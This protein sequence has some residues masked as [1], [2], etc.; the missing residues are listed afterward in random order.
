MKNVLIIAHLLYATPRIPGLA[1]YLRE[2][3]WQPIILTA[4]LPEK[5]N[6][7]FR[8][9]ETSYRDALGLW[10]RLLRINPDEDIRRQVKERF[11]V[12]SKKSLMDFILTCCGAVVNYPDITHI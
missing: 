12:T 2:F 3:G 5:L 4:P 9:I 10:K 6:M 7:Q 11:G 8:V 1:K